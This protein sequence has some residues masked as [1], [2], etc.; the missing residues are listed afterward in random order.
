MAITLKKH[1]AR[2]QEIAKENPE[3]LEK[4]IICASD[5]EG[6]SFQK[7]NFDAGIGH[8]NDYNEFSNGSLIEG[9]INCTCI[10]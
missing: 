1:I 10:N 8:F 7:V 2:L 3:L 9:E 6:N 4:P 5:D